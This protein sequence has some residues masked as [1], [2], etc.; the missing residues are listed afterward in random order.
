[1]EADSQNGRPLPVHSRVLISQ[2]VP[3]ARI[4]YNALGIPRT[5]VAYGH[6]ERKGVRQREGGAVR[7]CFARIASM[8]QERH[9]EFFRREF[10]ATRSLIEEFTT[11]LSQN[12]RALD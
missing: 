10:R 8:F 7:Y 1:M 9:P 12:L 2:Y 6:V 11:A 3:L 5:I 4:H